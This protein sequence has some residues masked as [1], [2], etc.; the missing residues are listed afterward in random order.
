[1]YVDPLQFTLNMTCSKRNLHRV[2][3]S[4]NHEI[5]RSNQTLECEVPK[6]LKQREWWCILAQ[7]V[8]L[9]CIIV[10]DLLDNYEQIKDY[11]S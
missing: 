5:C 9:E 7:K 2:L 6:T 10:E 1:M 11:I 8:E 3:N 4:L